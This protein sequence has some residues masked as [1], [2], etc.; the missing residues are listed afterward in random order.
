MDT[1]YRQFVGLSC[2]VANLAG[3]LAVQWPDTEN[4][5]ADSV[6]LAVRTDLPGGA[7]AFSHHRTP[8]HQL[9]DGT[10]LAYAT[11]LTIPALTAELDRHG[12]V[13]LLVDNARL[14]W[15]PSYGT[16][17]AAP[18][19]LLVRGRAGDRWDVLDLFA[20]LLPGGE[21][22]PYAGTVGTSVLRAA[23]DP[24]APFSAAQ[25]RRNGLAFGFPVPV[26]AGATW[27]RRMP[28]DGAVAELPGEWAY[29]R[30]ALAFLTDRLLADGAAAEAYLDDLWTAAAHHI[31]R[32][33]RHGAAEPAAAW[34]RLP[35]ALRFAVDSA[36]RGRARPGLLST[37]L[38]EL[39]RLEHATPARSEEHR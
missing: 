24:I 14:P 28:D 29:D 38:A 7:L 17:A 1:P 6:R 33:H 5:L 11:G 18:H 15:S 13:L 37:T 23:L 26:P 3:Y 36:R 21:Q 2:Y 25:Q 4:R 8:L 20:G 12:R 9:P 35:G 10:A 30:A 39:D 16:R 19:W 32:H 22:R 34:R 31:F 27:L